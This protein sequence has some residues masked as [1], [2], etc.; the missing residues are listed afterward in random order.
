MFEINKE[1][2]ANKQA[3]REAKNMLSKMITEMILSSES[4]PESMKLSVMVLDK[5]KQLNEILYE[6][7][8]CKYI[9]PGKRANA[10]TLKK[11]LEYLELVEV[12]IKQFA[13]STPFVKDTEED[14]E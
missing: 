10:K 1:E 13:D 7:I 9:A 4:A 2:M 11:V 12:G 8:L 6:E 5:A 14:K 3:E